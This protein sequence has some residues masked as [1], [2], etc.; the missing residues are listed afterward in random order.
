MERHMRKIRTG[1]TAAL[2]AATP[3]LAQAD[4]SN[5]VVKLGL[6]TDFSSIYADYSGQANQT[7]VQMAIDD[8]GG[9]VGGKKI[10]LV[11]ADF[12]NKADVSLAIARKWIDEEGVDA[13]V[14]AP[15][16]AVAAAM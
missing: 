16:S 1:L 2:L 9:T 15:N 11:T 3:W 10:E 4:I 7:A 12:Q 14:D 6:L 8:F 5:N 13:I